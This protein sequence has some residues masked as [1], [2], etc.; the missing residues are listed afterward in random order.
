MVNDINGFRNRPLD[1]LDGKPAGRSNSAAGQ[2]GA[3]ASKPTAGATD[4]VQLTESAARLRE[5]DALLSQ[6]SEVDS[7]RVAA[8]RQAIAEG[9]YNVDSV[10]VADKLIQLEQS[11]FGD[12]QA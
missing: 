2:P 3:P 4:T 1:S 7:A 10:H 6:T 12:K 9:R 5:L 11:L 8:L